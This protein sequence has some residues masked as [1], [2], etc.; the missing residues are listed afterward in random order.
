MIETVVRE[1]R[2]IGSVRSARY[3][4]TSATRISVRRHRKRKPVAIHSDLQP[5]S[6][7]WHS[8]KK[9]PAQRKAPPRTPTKEEPPAT[10]ERQSIVGFFVRNASTTASSNK[11]PFDMVVVPE[12]EFDLPPPHNVAFSNLE[13]TVVELE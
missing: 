6:Q 11:T 8:V 3:P 2:D 7:S 5:R 9:A 1:P 10:P 12:D 13:H 4:S